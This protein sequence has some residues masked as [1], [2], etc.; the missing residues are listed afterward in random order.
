MIV[1]EDHKTKVKG[2]K[3]YA[4]CVNS[5]VGPRIKFHLHQL[6]RGTIKRNFE[7]GKATNIT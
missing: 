4:T 5:L 1:F 6:K 3:P 7:K 2:L